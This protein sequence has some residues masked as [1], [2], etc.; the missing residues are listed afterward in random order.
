MNQSIS[1]TRS[2]CKH[3]KELRGL[4]PGAL[5]KN[6]PTLVNR[7]LHTSRHGGHLETEKPHTPRLV[8]ELRCREQVQLYSV[9]TS[10]C[11]CRGP[12]LCAEVSLQAQEGA[13][14]IFLFVAL[15]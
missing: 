6:S 12:T 14:F 8:M 7:W 4:L 15:A 5:S 9:S 10:I 3:R 1:I 13:G 2:G 11:V